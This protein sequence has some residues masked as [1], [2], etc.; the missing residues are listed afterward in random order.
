MR[1]LVQKD[2]HL[3][4][5]GRMLSPPA[6]SR[7]TRRRMECGP[8]LPARSQG[9]QVVGLVVAVCSSVPACVCVGA[10]LGTVRV[11]TDTVITAA[12]GQSVSCDV[13]GAEIRV[14]VCACV[15]A[16]ARSCV[17]HRVC[18]CDCDTLTHT[19]TH[20]HARARAHTHTYTHSP[21][22][23]HA[24]SPSLCACVYA[25][26]YTVT[27]T[28]THAC[29]HARITSIALACAHC[30][31]ASPLKLCRC[32][33]HALQSSWTRSTTAAFAPSGAR[34]RY[35]C[36]AGGPGLGAFRSR[37]VPGCPLCVRIGAARFDPPQ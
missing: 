35:V 22:P 20:T 21:T 32:N 16:C 14:H 25:C 33:L 1:D 7:G 13:G 8:R 6:V 31:V 26:V 37:V 2:Q 5:R 9:R 19:H 4:I 10:G 29:T 15:R 23:T 11:I 3:F 36:V 34:T 28:H 18:A 17:C 12:N 27:H 24:R 30:R